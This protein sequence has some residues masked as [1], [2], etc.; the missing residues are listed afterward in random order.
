MPCNDCFTIALLT[1]ITVRVT[2]ITLSKYQKNVANNSSHINSYSKTQATTGKCQQKPTVRLSHIIRHKRSCCTTRYYIGKSNYKFYN[3]LTTICD[4]GFTKAY[5]TT[6]IQH[7]LSST[8]ALLGCFPISQNVFSTPFPYKVTHKPMWTI[9][10]VQC[11]LLRT[12]TVDH[13]LALS[14]F[15]VFSPIAIKQLK[16]SL[17]YSANITGSL[18]HYSLNRVHEHVQYWSFSSFTGFFKRQRSLHDCASFESF[19]VGLYQIKHLQHTLRQL[20]EC[21]GRFHERQ[22]LSN[23]QAYSQIFHLHG[24]VLQ[25]RSYL[26]N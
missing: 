17:H 5:A 9:I 10:G 26:S 8:V 18:G 6:S 12:T 19:N 20:L 2:R 13:K 14:R 3:S 15:N 11:S 23:I 24:I 4:T 7:C 22:K 16:A 25:F 21:K 1:A